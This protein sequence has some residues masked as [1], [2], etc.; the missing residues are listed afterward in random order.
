MVVSASGQSFFSGYPKVVGRIPI[1]NAG[2]QARDRSPT[3]PKT[4][5][6]SALFGYCGYNFPVASLLLMC[7]VMK[8]KEF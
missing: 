3:N 6:T 5:S 4:E 1:Y 7:N 2:R 8:A